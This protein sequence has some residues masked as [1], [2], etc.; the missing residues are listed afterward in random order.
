MKITAHCIIK[1]EDIW[2]WYAIQSVLPFVDKILIC[3]N[4]SSDKTEQIIKSINSQK[5]SLEVTGRLTPKML[6]DKRRQQIKMTQTD[7]FLILDGDEVWPQRQIKKLLLEAQNASTDIS[8]FINKT[9]NCLGDVFHYLPDSIGSYRIG[10]YQGNLNIRLIRKTADLNITGEYPLESYIN[11]LG[12]ITKQ[13]ANL[14]FVDCWYLHTGF[15]KRSSVDN[16]KTSGSLGK[17]KFW[18]KGR[19]MDLKEL[20]ETLFLKN[21]T[22][23]FN[24]LAKRSFGYELT[25][26]ILDPLL[27]IKRK[28]K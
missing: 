24:P 17:K 23:L 22:K 14:K 9:R 20:P 21:P 26:N 25:S 15:L 1:N 11:K 2:V 18:E 7:W 4:D 10:P 16:A 19:K 3:V 28:I 8:A 6:V 12:P 13:V 27:K 5:I